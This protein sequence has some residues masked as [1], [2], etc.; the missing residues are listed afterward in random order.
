[1]LGRQTV[2]ALN[3]TPSFRN[4]CEAR[5]WAP[6]RSLLIRDHPLASHGMRPFVGRS[7][8]PADGRHE[9]SRRRHV[10]FD[11]LDTAIHV[12]APPARRR[13][14]RPDVGRRGGRDRPARGPADRQRA[15][16]CATALDGDL[17][18]GS[19]R[20]RR[21]GRPRSLSFLGL[22]P[23]IGWPFVI[24]ALLLL[25]NLAYPR[26]RPSDRPKSVASGRHLEPVD[27]NR[28]GSPGPHHG[29]ALSGKP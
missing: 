18:P 9:S 25:A 28:G 24:A 14:E 3:R 17:C 13:P 22:R 26:P 15:L 23:P 5:A 27:A 8:D 10:D 7:G 20:R 2:R 1:M 16:V 4:C 21:F 19:L 29:R 11:G 12:R 6:W